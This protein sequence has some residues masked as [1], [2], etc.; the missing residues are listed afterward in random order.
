MKKEIIKKTEL[1]RQIEEFTS[2]QI[3]VPDSVI[4]ELLQRYMNSIEGDQHLF[5]E[6]YPKTIFQAKHLIGSG[7]V[8][9]AIIF[10]KTTEE[11]ENKN[12]WSVKNSEI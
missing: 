1:G 10:L 12:V 2:Q 3:Y 6:G 7:I 4:I 9:D 11:Q 5:I 8:P